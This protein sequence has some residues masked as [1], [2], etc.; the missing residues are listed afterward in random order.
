MKLDY[1]PDREFRGRITYIYPN[2]D[3]KT[4]AA[5]RRNMAGAMQARMAEEARA[6]F[7]MS[8]EEQDRLQKQMLAW[9]R[10]SPEQRNAAREK[11]L[12][13]KNASPSSTG[14]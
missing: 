7:K 2:V 8:P 6:F 11:F 5:M 4:R 1:L 14:R 10:L 13:L 3:D 12:R 9:V